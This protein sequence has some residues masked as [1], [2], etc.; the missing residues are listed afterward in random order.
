MHE[1][2]K[3]LIAG[4]EIFYILVPG[5]HGREI[6]QQLMDAGFKMATR[7][8]CN[9]TFNTKWIGVYPLSK[10]FGYYFTGDSE[11]P[12]YSY[13]DFETIYERGGYKPFG[14]IYNTTTQEDYEHDAMNYLRM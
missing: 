10:E 3:N 8:M 9:S 14:R 6:G 5:A 7:Q 13:S 4:N 1:K 12:N 2:L 11:Y